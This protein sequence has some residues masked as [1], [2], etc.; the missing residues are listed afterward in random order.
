M[1][2]QI[3]YLNM[4]LQGCKISATCIN[5]F[6][7]RHFAFYDLVLQPGCRISKIRHFLGEIALAMRASS[8]PIIKTISSKGI[9]R[10]QLTHAAPEMINLVELY[11]KNPRPATFLPFLL[12]ETDEGQPLWVDMSKNPHLLVA[13]TTGSGKSIFLHNIIFNALKTENLDLYLVDTKLVEFAPYVNHSKVK[14]VAQSYTDAIAVLENL[15]E[16]MED[17]YALLKRFK[18]SSVEDNPKLFK[19]ILFVIDEA[20]DLMLADK[21]RMFEKLLIKLAA[22]SRAA[23]IYIVLATQRPSVDVITGLIKANFPARMACKVASRTDSQVIMDMP[24]AENLCGRGDALFKSANV[25]IARLQIAFTS[26]ALN[27]RHS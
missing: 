1:V 5:A 14:N 11:A 7:H 26:A 12:G 13:G 20:A 27:C 4:V 9:V 23:G 24:G 21:S 15:C 19:K 18:I 2:D 25:D 8:Q 6:K 3:Q 10:L 17:R 22:K 16:I